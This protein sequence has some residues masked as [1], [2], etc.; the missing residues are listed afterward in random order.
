MKILVT[1]PPGI[2]KSTVID[3]V[4]SQYPGQRHGIVARELLD[5]TGIRNGFTSINTLGES[6]QFMFH[7]DRPTAE[8]IG[9]EYDVD[10]QAIDAFVVPEL[11][12]GIK[13]PDGLTYIDEIGRAQA[14][15]ETFIATLRELFA[16]D[17]NILGAIV[18]DDEPW[19][20][21]FKQAP[22]ICT[23][24]VT[25]QNRNALPNI[26][27]A[28]F[29]GA[30]LFSRLNSAQ[31]AKVFAMLK[32]FVASNQFNAAMKL[33]VNALPYVVD[34]RIRLLNKEGPTS[35]FLISGHTRDHTVFWNDDEGTF[36]CDCDLA[37]GRGA[38]QNKAE[39]CSHHMSILL[40]N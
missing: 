12:K 39:T 35:E 9:G 10:I 3:A 13:D 38:F 24:E 32:S 6:R 30:T 15:S 19:S 29:G 28:A 16:T 11:Q 37:N 2:G 22:G 27:L 17:N 23:I 40:S 8:T 7:T 20:L 5:K 33:F 18:Y 14:K 36:I 21:E 25:A 34:H 26:L 31:Q 1:A 4:V